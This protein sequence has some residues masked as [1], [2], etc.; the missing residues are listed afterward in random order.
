MYQLAS[1]L[2]DILNFPLPDRIRQLPIMFESCPI[3]DLQV[4]SLN[5]VFGL[6]I[7][8]W[9]FFR[10]SFQCLFDTF[11]VLTTILVGASEQSPIR[12]TW[13]SKCSTSSFIRTLN[14]SSSC[15]ASLKIPSSLKSISV[16]CR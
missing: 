10:L 7:N 16:N 2:T 6:N 9:Q 8:L 13:N 14:F 3:K 1:R 4:I 12:T 11:S 5:Y 15:I